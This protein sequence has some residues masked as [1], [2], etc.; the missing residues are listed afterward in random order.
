MSGNMRIFPLIAFGLYMLFYYFHNQQRVPVTGRK[1]LVDTSVQQ[2]A[3]LGLQSY[4]EILH[5]SQTVQSGPEVDRGCAGCRA[6]SRL[7][8][9]VGT[10]YTG[11]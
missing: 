5:Q 2:D 11:S 7:L 4:Q 3:A 8:R 9:L 10:G 6:L 1:H